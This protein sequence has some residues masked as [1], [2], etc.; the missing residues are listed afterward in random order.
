MILIDILFHIH[1]FRIFHSSD[2]PCVCRST[3]FQSAA[4]QCLKTSCTE[5]DIVTANHLRTQHCT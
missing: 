5:R 4:L 3:V 1:S 2:L